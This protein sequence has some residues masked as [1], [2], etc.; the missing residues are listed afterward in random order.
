MEVS[1]TFMEVKLTSILTS[2]EVEVDIASM[3]AVIDI[4]GSDIASMEVKRRSHGSEVICQIG[5]E[6]RFVRFHKVP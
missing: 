3:E 6:T 4:H 2:M 1:V 5:S